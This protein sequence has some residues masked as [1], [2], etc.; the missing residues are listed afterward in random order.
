MDKKNQP[1]NFDNSSN[2]NSSEN[3]NYRIRRE[4][5][6][7]TNIEKR[8]QQIEKKR[9]R[10]EKRQ[11]IKQFIV[12][13]PNNILSFTG[14]VF[15]ATTKK[16]VDPNF[17]VAVAMFLSLY[18]NFDQK[19]TL[20]KKEQSIAELNERIEQ[21][22]NPYSFKN[23]RTY[24]KSPRFR[25]V[26][27]RGGILLIPIAKQLYNHWSTNQQLSSARQQLSEVTKENTEIKQEIVH[28][29]EKS[30]SKIERIKDSY[31]TQISKLHVTLNRF[32]EAALAS[33][34]Q[35]REILGKM[36]FYKNE[37]AETIENNESLKNEIKLARS[38]NEK[39]DQE[40]NDLSLQMKVLENVVS[41]KED[42][43]ARLTADLLKVTEKNK[44][45]SLKAQK[46]KGQIKRTHTELLKFQQELSSQKDEVSK[47]TSEKRKLKKELS[48]VISQQVVAEDTI[49]DLQLQTNKA[50]TKFQEAIDKTNRYA[51]HMDSVNNQINECEKEANQK[52]SEYARTS[53]IAEDKV[54]ELSRMI[55][56]QEVQ[57][58][59]KD[60]QSQQLENEVQLTKAKLNDNVIENYQLQSELSKSKDQLKEVSGQQK[61]ELQKVI[62]TTKRTINNNQK[63]YA[64]LQRQFKDQSNQLT[65]AYIEQEGLIEQV[66]KLNDRLHNQDK[67]FFARLQSERQEQEEKFRS[68]Q[69]ISSKLINDL[70]DQQ[71]KDQKKSWWQKIPI[72][73]LTHIEMK[74]DVPE[75]KESIRESYF[76]PA[77][78]TAVPTE[79]SHVQKV[80]EKYSNKKNKWE[81]VTNQD[82]VPVKKD[83]S[84]KK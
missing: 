81:V 11:N 33:A 57:L 17:L 78:S 83:R 7:K 55:K 36:Q 54:T 49:K 53:K 47:L 26:F 66:K 20:E 77:F 76:Y 24:I 14:Q 25:S 52:I 72:T 58:R 51:M 84:S 35:E 46:L 2:D 10:T 61:R 74:S 43:E 32:N 31:D 42:I 13:I 80:T 39:K 50:E 34:Q 73:L 6:K 23:I 29:K 37:L 59:Q 68:T 15:K 69:E 4:Y 82:K 62:A 71:M 70:L 41:D 16:I 1:K 79:Q 48:T 5:I 8:R 44:M 28:V 40:I 60:K 18:F 9:L 45:F 64:Q 56:R 75:E 63:K 21:L 19:R 3:L 30:Q 27:I 65:H 12:N 22:E 67:S 38:L